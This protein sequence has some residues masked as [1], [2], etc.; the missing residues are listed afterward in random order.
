MYKIELEGN[1]YEMPAGWDEVN[2]KQM[3]LINNIVTNEYRSHIYLM[4]DLISALSGIDKE[5][6]YELDINELSKFDFSW[7]STTIE[8]KLLNE[9]EISGVKYK[10]VNDMKHLKLGEY[11]DLDYYMKDLTNNLHYIVGILLRPEVDGK[12]EKYN[13]DTLEERSKIFY[14]NLKVDFVM[15][16]VD[17]FQNGVNGS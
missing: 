5:I 14:D 2:L 3:L 10:L 16:I 1:N 15:G 6:L 17:F 13:S 11:A 8:K 4:I 7:I 12:V 9:I